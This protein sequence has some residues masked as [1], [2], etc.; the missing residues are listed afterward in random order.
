MNATL[1]MFVSMSLLYPAPPAP[2]ASIYGNGYFGVMLAEEGGGVV[3]TRILPD[4]PAF[5]SPLQEGDRILKVDDREIRD[6]NDSRAV[7]SSLRPGM[8]YEVIIKRGETTIRFRIKPT[9]RQ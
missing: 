5:R 4:S 7:I 2:E 6:T 9:I 3:V 1:S 8:S